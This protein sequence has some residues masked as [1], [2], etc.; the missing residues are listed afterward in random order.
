MKILFYRTI[1]AVLLFA[2]LLPRLNADS[3]STAP[4]SGGQD[5]SRFFNDEP[6]VPHNKAL[7]LLEL[8]GM[9]AGTYLACRS[10]I[11]SENM[12]GYADSQF[13]P[14]VEKSGIALLT[15][16]AGTL[17]G[18]VT[19][20]VAFGPISPDYMKENNFNDGTKVLMVGFGAAAMAAGGYA[21]Y[22]MGGNSPDKYG[23]EMIAG[24]IAGAIIGSY[25]GNLIGGI[26]FPDN[27][28]KKAGV[29]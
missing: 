28:K 20:A 3:A 27:G 16:F 4:Q 24:S 14:K 21:G 12:A 18:G 9:F 23:E 19:A 13:F 22:M 15:A 11:M 5:E 1:T 6:A 25:F 26:I 29:Q 8:S 17:L 2:A 7:D 10:D